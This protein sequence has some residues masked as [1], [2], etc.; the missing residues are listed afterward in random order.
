MENEQSLFISIFGQI[1]DPRVERNKDH[2]LLDIIALA[3]CA[4]VCGA[5][6]WT[7]IESFG[8]AK[9]A[10]LRTFLGLEKGIPSHDT[11]GR[12]FALLDPGVFQA[13]FQ[14]W[15][16]AL[17]SKVE[18]VVAIDG[19][20]VRRSHDHAKSKQAIHLVSAWAT[21]T[22]IAL[23]HVKVDDKSNEITAIPQLLKLLQINGCM[24]TIDAIGCQ[25]EIAQAI[26]D[27]GADYLLA[28]KDNQK[29]L[30]EDVEQEFKEAARQGFKHMEHT[31]FETLEK[32]HG[33]IETRQYWY[34][35]DVQGIGTLEDWPQLNGMVMCRA[36]RNLKGKISVEDRFF[37]TSA[38]HG[39]SKKIA[40]SIR[41]HWGIENSLH[42]VLDIAFGEDQA[43]IRAENADQ[44]MAT[45]RKMVINVIKPDKSRKGGVRAKRL[46]AGWDD[47]YLR[48]II[49]RM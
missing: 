11:I 49:T 23:G 38:T 36:T 43:R 46:Q 47:A 39:D 18:G 32:D 17:Q 4:A 22:G 35:H 12:V 30:R 40:E 13:C 33:R 14:Q 34:T 19:K 8:K 6:G 16:R 42:W 3:I 24:V 44:N 37:I 9:Q 41:A 7:D 28:V 20:T 45:V 25:K 21:E 10:W 5:D 15:V 26:L 48:E 2:K 29:T 31:Y 27:K 1:E